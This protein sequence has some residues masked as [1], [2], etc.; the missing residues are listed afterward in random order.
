MAKITALYRPSK[1][2]QELRDSVYRDVQEMIDERNR[3][4]PQ[5]NGENGDRTLIQYI[6]DSD[7]RLN[8]Y[9]PSREEQDKEEWQA[10]VFNPV[11]REKL[12]AVVAGV[13]QRFPELQYQAS[14]K[15]GLFS[16]QRAEF[17]KQLVR[18]SRAVTNPQ[19]DIFFEAWEM[20]GKG[21]V[22]KY[23]GYLKTKYKRKF[24]KSFDL[25]T[26]R[27]DFDERDE[28]VDD[29]PID[30][31][32]PIQEFFISDFTIFNVQD[33][34][35]VAWIQHYNKEALEMEFGHLPNFKFIKDKQGFSKRYHG[36]TVSYFY[37][38]W[39][40]RV[41][42]CEDYEVVRYYNKLEDRY[43]IWVNGVDML[44]SPLLW[45]RANKLYPFS[46]SIL[47]PF[48]DRQF[49]YGKSLPSVLE[50]N[51]D[52]D[53]TIWNTMLDKLYRSLK[54]PMLVGLPNKDLLDIEEE[55]V[56]EDNKFYVPDVA[57]VKPMPYD[58]V[59]SGDIAMLQ[60]TA[61]MLDLASVDANQS[62]IQGRG[63]TATE[64]GIAD[65]NAARLK[66]IF[67]T[68]LEDLWIQKTR[69]RIENILINYMKQ[70]T[71]TIIGKEGTEII[72]KATTIFSV[73]D[74]KFAD[75]ST[76]ILGIQVV[77]EAQ[78]LPTRAEIETREN[79][80][81]QNGQNY[82]LIAVTSDYLDD[83]HL[84]F[85]VVS[86][87]LKERDRMS[88][89]KKIALKQELLVTLYPEYA[90]S[91]KEMMFEEFLEVYGEN[92]EDWN[93]PAQP[94]MEEKP[95]E[96]GPLAQGAQINNPL[97]AP[98]PSSNPNLSL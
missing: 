21:T 32:V 9:T 74:T 67:F 60:A 27:V 43:E 13:A 97:G 98:A 79:A 54:P 50:G 65:Q 15:E 83:W 20:C 75:G 89:E 12:K 47:E 2:V 68:M 73:K 22:V 76:G 78:D 94:Q 37:D 31:E 1:K 77:D 93:P 23:D 88:E 91:N 36:D 92:I 70:K 82:K 45:G 46:K 40:N 41:D 57:Q 66:G 84:D 6:N 4:Y 59:T 48:V 61:R 69:I 16:T 17:V 85:T 64:A 42:D 8:A 63:V 14:N 51:Q 56:N 90:A 53:N 26:G 58:G 3:T 35:K 49:F 24:I 10:N 87:S 5:F 96:N 39:A 28:V 71:D 44:I 7:R 29:R 18:H 62:G 86:D 81:I 95:D 33:Q 25:T 55:L 72:Q 30:L 38:K 19:L 34:P 80:M 52:V 11:T